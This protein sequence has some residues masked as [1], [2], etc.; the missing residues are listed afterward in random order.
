MQATQTDNLLLRINDLERRLSEAYQLI[1]AI[2]DGE[3]DAFA[4]SRD[5]TPKI[6]T[7]QSGDYAYRMLIEKFGEGALNLTEDGLIV[8]CNT[9]FFNLLKVPYEK[10]I[11]SFIYDWIEEGSHAGFRE[12]FTGALTGN[13]KGEIVFLT[14]D[15]SIPVY[16]SLT[17]LQPNL[18]TVGMVITDLT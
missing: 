5:D 2:K 18:P 13:S 10:V 16:C 4:I 1:D 3:V 7:L 17:S 14:G 15:R 8:Y 6:Y 9:S 11:G 12:L